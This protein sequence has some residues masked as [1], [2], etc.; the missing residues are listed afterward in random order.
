MGEA[1]NFYG[2][3]FCLLACLLFVGV[4][5][6]VP[7]RTGRARWWSSVLGRMLVTKA[8]A[9]AGLMAIVVA[10]YLFDLDLEWVRSARGVFAAIV[11]VMMVYQSWMVYRIQTDKE[12]QPS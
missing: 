12:D 2:S 7:L 5:T 3:L 6:V 10:L 9:L 1:L 8:L 11:A 4:Y